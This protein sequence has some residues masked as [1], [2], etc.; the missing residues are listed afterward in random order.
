ML[1]Q[2]RY[3]LTY[4]FNSSIFFLGGGGNVMCKNW[5][6]TLNQEEHWF[7]MYIQQPRSQGFSFSPPN[8]TGKSSG[9]EIDALIDW[10]IEMNDTSDPHTYLNN[11]KNCSLI[12]TPEIATW[13]FQASVLKG[14]CSDCPDKVEITS[15]AVSFL[16]NPNFKHN[17]RKE[18]GSLLLP[19]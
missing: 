8:F 10:L 13:M 18:I 6:H 9:N 2:A 14:N 1:L 15:T 4:I 5:Y 19:T 7:L 17:Q 16:Y 3:E 11:F 12:W